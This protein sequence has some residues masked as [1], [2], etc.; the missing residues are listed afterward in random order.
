M[1]IKAKYHEYGIFSCKQ[2]SIIFSLL[3]YEIFSEFVFTIDEHFQLC[4]ENECKTITITKNWLVLISVISFCSVYVNGVIII[5]PKS[6][7]QVFTGHLHRNL[8]VTA[9]ELMAD[10]MLQQSRIRITNLVVHAACSHVTC[11]AAP[12]TEKSLKTPSLKTK[13]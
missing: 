11:I 5:C 12:I 9:H 13:K 3:Y 1:H 7:L 10:S 8:H 2:S 4:T 6:S